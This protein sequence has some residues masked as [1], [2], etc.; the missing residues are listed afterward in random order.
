MFPPPFQ[1][2]NFD[3]RNSHKVELVGDCSVFVDRSHPII[4]VFRTHA[5]SIGFDVGLLQ[6]AAGRVYMSK[7]T[8]YEC[9]RRFKLFFKGS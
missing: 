8:F 6:D 4:Q 1:E 3:N 5:D 7:P 9:C 2:W